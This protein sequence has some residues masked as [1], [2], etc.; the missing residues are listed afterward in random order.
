LQLQ[1]KQKQQRQSTVKRHSHYTR[2]V[3]TAAR[4][5]FGSA[6]DTL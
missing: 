6:A 4:S 5:Q 2:G 3:Q 1:H